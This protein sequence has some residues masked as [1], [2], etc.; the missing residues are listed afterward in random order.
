M[1]A[2][3]GL[4]IATGVDKPSGQTCTYLARWEGFEPPTF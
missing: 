2:L 3:F 1:T 4:P